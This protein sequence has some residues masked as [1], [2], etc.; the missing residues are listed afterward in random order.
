VLLY[1]VFWSFFLSLLFPILRI[2]DVLKFL[3]EGH[4]VMITGWSLANITEISYVSANSTKTLAF[5]HRMSGGGMEDISCTTPHVN[6]SG[7]QMLRLTDTIANWSLWTRVY[8]TA[9]SCITQGTYAPYATSNAVCLVCPNGGYCPGGER[10]W[11]LPGYWALNEYTS[12]ITCAS[13][14]ACPG[15]MLPAM[16]SAGGEGGPSAMLPAMLSS[17]LAEEGLTVTTECGVGYEGI[18]CS[19]CS[20][21]F[22][23]AGIHSTIL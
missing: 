5:S 21:G 19:Y 10:V 7:Y 20:E 17:M 9:S 1:N 12:P 11:P 14:H 13:T 8:Y 4:T 16:L 18:A 22:Y 23:R 2:P 15:A 3:G 6:T